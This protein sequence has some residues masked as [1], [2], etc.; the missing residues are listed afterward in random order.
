MPSIQRGQVDRIKPGHWRLRWYDLDG[1]R[2]SKQ[3]FKSRSAAWTW[4]REEVESQ[5]TGE[6]A[7]KAE[8][9][10]S[11]FAELYLERHAAAV[12]PRTIATLRNASGTL[13]GASGIS[14]SGIWRP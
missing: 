4:Y 10:L 8:L 14:L 11:E 1:K 6:P 7:A 12:R 2:H 3:P 9:T 5:L 13:S